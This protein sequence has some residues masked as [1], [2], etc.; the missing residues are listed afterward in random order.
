MVF[1]TTPALAVNSPNTAKNTDVKN[2]LETKLDAR[3]EKLDA[4]IA[5]KDAKIAEKLSDIKARIASK[6]SELKTKLQTFKDQLKAK[7][8]ER[9]NTNLNKINQNLVAIMQK[10]L[11][12]MSII[13]NKLEARVTRGT[14]DIK[15]PASAKVAILSAR[16]AIATAS[17]AL[18][19]QSQKDYTIQVT[20]ESRIKF[21]AQKQR[22]LLHNDLVAIRKM[23]IDAKQAVA[24]A[25][26]I[27]KAGSLGNKEGTE[28]GKE[29]TTSGQ[30]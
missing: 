22:D 3:I 24:N 14:P 21:D 27:A 17:A 8:A 25:I 4:K 2:K 29:A 28:S 10:H 12:K 11:D 30:Q 26:R 9:V 16:K 7:I 6:E 5:S 18:N 23:V 1:I 15:N 20:T 19:I 13:L